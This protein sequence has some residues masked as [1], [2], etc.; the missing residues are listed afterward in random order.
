VNYVIS[1]DSAGRINATVGSQVTQSVSGAVAIN[2]GYFFV[3][4]TFNST[5]RKIYVNSIDVTAVGG[6]NTNLPT[7]TASVVRIGNSRLVVNRKFDGAIDEI[8]I[9]KRVITPSEIKSL[10]NSGLGLAIV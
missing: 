7:D 3:G 6:G 10:Y 8:P 9:W 2:T 1:I 4:M 5:G